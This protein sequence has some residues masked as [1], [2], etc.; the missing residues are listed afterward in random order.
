MQYA[1]FNMLTKF[2][3]ENNNWKL[4]YHLVVNGA[5]VIVSLTAADDQA[6]EVQAH[7][8]VGSLGLA[9]LAG[10]FLL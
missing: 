2:A 6:V 10:R 8:Q 1:N 3:R 9:F 7:P 4:A 5:V